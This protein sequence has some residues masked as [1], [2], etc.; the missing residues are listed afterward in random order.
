M[1]EEH[2]G[3][4]GSHGNR[5]EEAAPE[6]LPFLQAPE[7]SSLTLDLAQW[8]RPGGGGVISDRALVTTTINSGE[9]LGGGGN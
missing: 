7:R 3:G 4:W 1:Q 6:R 9:D 2:K 8:K 5:E